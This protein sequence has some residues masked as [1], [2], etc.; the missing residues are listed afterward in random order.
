MSDYSN[1]KI[2]KLK[3]Y[4]TGKFYIGSTKNPL[5]TPKK[6]ARLTLHESNYRNFIIQEEE[7]NVYHYK[8]FYE[9]I[10]NDNYKIKLIEN[11]PCDNF[12]SV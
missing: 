4:T 5:E 12:L 2:Y 6:K 7:K 8:Y 1:G 3:C 9:V 11:Y 10:E